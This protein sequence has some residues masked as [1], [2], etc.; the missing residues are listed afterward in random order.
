MADESG[1]MTVQQWLGLG[2]QASIMLTVLGFGLTATW[3][4]AT[5]LF[6]NPT[7]LVRAVLSMSVVMPVVV[8]ILVAWVDFRYPVALALVALAVSPV[9]PI[10]Q[11]KELTA[12]GR[13]DYVVGLMVAMS[14]LAIVLVPLSLTILDRVFDKHGV[15]TVGAIAAIMAKTVLAPLAVGLALH[16]WWPASR[17][18]SGAVLAVA[19]ILLAVTALILLVGLWPI[20][21]T[22]IGNGMIVA[23]AVVALVGLLVGHALG[24]PMEADRTALAMSTASRHPAVALAVA[25]S[26]PLGEIK[27]ELAIILAYLVVATIVCIPYQKWRERH[28]G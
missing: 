25:T 23:M 28:A 8:A 27:T 4:Q 22:F 24:G 16:R 26:G 20:V 6:R 9:P 14:V 7:L 18:A 11:K 3:S 5:F 15:V 12:G 10:V 21:R 2:L 17:K 19:G 1:V 13:M